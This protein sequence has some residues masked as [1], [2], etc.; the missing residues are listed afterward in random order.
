MFFYVWKRVRHRIISVVVICFVVYSVNYLLQAH[1][2]HREEYSVPEYDRVFITEETDRETLF[3]QTGLGE[4]AVEKLISEEQFE[5]AL[6]LQNAVFEPRDTDCVSL[7]GWFTREDRREED[8]RIVLVD[9]Q[10]GDILLT[11]STHSIGWR[12]GHAGLVLNEYA[13]L[14]SVSLGE[15][16]A[17]VGVSHWKRYSNFVV[18]RVK[19]ADEELKKEVVSFGREHLNDISYRL[20]AGWLGEKAPGVDEA[21][22]G[23]HCSYLIWY[24]WNRFGY[25]LDSD[26]GRLVTCDDI[27]KSPLVEIVQIYGLNLESKQKKELLQN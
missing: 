17:I 2:A 18:L 8:E 4:Q 11:F 15:R 10:P 20:L 27:L 22:F 23:A 26:G 1:W 9:L 24:A 19:G 3:L 5:L 12:H 6:K 13:V 7:L 21:W 14:E 25:D 16:S